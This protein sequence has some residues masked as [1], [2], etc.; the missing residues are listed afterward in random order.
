MRHQNS[1]P[2]L[3]NIRLFIIDGSP[4]DRSTYIQWIQHAAPIS[5][6][7]QEME[8]G[9]QALEACASIP[10]HCILLDNQL[11]DMTGL[12]FLS[13]L[14]S[15]H[16][17]S[18]SP[19]IFL[20][21]R[22][23]EEIATQAIK[24]G[25]QDYFIK[26][27]LSEEFLWR[28]IQ[29]AIDQLTTLHRLHALERQSS[30]I[31]QSSVDGLVVVG[32]NG[33]IRFTNP[34]AEHLFQQTAEELLA[35]PFGYPMVPGQTSEIMIGQQHT[36]ATPVEMRVVP[37]EWGSEPAY[38]TS[39][40]DLTERR[41]A[42]EER[43]RHE[44][45]RQYAQKLESLGVLAGGIAHDFNNLLMA[46]VAR[47]GLALRALPP[48]SPARNHL[49]IIE[50]SG[51]RGGELANQMLTFAGETQLV[52]QPIN[53]QQFLKDSQ[54]FLRSTVSRRITLT[55]NLGTDLPPIYGDRSQL[56]QL[57][58]NVVTNA[59]EAIGDQD[60]TISINTSTL[61]TSTQD[62][63][64]YHIMGDLPWG[65]CVSLNIQDTGNGMK[66]ELIPKIFDP[67]FTTKFP[68]RG[69]GL[70]T[71]LGLVRG[72]GAAI[73]VRSQV[74][75]GTEFF[76]IFPSNKKPS[77][78]RSPSVTLPMKPLINSSPTKILIVDDEEE[79]RTACSLI[80]NEIGF[81]AL[82]AQDGKA[83]S[84]IFE[85]YQDEIAL[86]FLDLTM[87]HL[88]GGQL[89]KVIKGLNPHVPIL[90]SS[91]YAEEEAMKHF[92]QSTISAFIQKP[93]QVEVLIAK[94]QELTGT[95]KQD[96]K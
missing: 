19:V 15:S 21:G 29:Q 30:T 20:I 61:D 75:Q 85:Q 3:T 38:L 13:R 41:K 64:Q 1:Q 82:V 14:R 11:A 17:P 48:D 94:I 66:P 89:A 26:N 52:F 72:H 32:T 27:T 57:L 83:G 79:V 4:T 93:F 8:T 24:L 73:A 2:P 45:E 43:Q 16:S 44:T 74:G 53:L 65:P 12:D 10:P 49:K 23:N 36:P 62:F 33:L 25:V 54:S 40:R 84:R 81:D 39:L 90:V 77:A 56:R 6:D 59:A 91:G 22:G 51:L 78:Q 47:A 69:L 86:V 60:G 58:M 9:E 70:A 68:G 28:H 87:P 71:L 63:S 96:E 31:L 92:T 37:I 5:L 76:F 50:K 67:F 34:A 88:D 7:I 55:L 18:N 46:I 35:S 95:G 80:L 42:E